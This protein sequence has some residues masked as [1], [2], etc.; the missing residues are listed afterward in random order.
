[1]GSWSQNN[2]RISV[3]DPQCHQFYPHCSVSSPQFPVRTLRQRSN[4]LKKDLREK[5]KLS[6]ITLK[7]DQL[8][9]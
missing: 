3:T 1:M 9:C 5:P 7:T 6:Q 4:V 2:G 8:P